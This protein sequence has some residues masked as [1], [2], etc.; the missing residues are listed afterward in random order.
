MDAVGCGSAIGS[1]RRVQELPA[2]VIQFFQQW[3]LRLQP[4]VIVSKV[5]VW[6]DP[7][8]VVAVDDDLGD[9]IGEVE[10]GGVVDATL[11]IE[12]RLRH[13]GWV[14]QTLVGQLCP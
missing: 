5:V 7:R 9:L 12:M 14:R 6:L 11:R 1:L 10:G 8:I 4:A 2:D 3:C 13:V